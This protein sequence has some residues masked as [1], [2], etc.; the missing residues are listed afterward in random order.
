MI[1]V[2]ADPGSPPGDDDLQM[3]DRRLA[4]KIPR[5]APTRHVAAVRAVVSSI[6]SHDH[7]QVRSVWGQG[8]KFSI[9][10]HV[11]TTES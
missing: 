7:A 9:S 1:A 5:S 3:E 11:G 2:P 6:S 4:L 8:P 10:Y